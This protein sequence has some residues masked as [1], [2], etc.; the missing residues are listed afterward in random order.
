MTDRTDNET[1]TDTHRHAAE[2]GRLE[3][4]PT[5]HSFRTYIINVQKH[6]QDTSILS[7][8]LHWLTVSR[9]RAANI[10]RGPCSD[11]SHVTAPFKLSFYYLL[12][13]DAGVQ[14]WTI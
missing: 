8:L 2:S 9:V 13:Y 1:Q 10:V 5:A 6:A 12:L 3:Q 4:S 11:F 7:F 14:R